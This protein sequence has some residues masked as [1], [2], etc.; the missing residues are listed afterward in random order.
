[1]NTLRKI[2]FLF[3]TPVVL[4]GLVFWDLCCEPRAFLF[5]KDSETLAPTKT[6]EWLK[7]I[8]R[9]WTKRS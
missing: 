4:V 3:I 5:L 7:R 8:K 1:M 6:E 9:M 2:V